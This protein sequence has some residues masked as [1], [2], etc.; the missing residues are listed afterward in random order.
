MVNYSDRIWIVMLWKTNIIFI[1]FSRL[2][3]SICLFLCL[4]DLQCHC[5]YKVH[6]WKIH[7][8]LQCR[9]IYLKQTWQEFSFSYPLLEF[10]RH[11]MAKWKL[12]LASSFIENLIF[13]IGSCNVSCGGIYKLYIVKFKVSNYFL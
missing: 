7:F 13:F 2:L 11:S 9:K 5:S 4:V 1:L 3:F 6:F 10:D 12:I 8:L